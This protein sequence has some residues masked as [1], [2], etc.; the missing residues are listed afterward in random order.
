MLQTHFPGKIYGNKIFKHKHTFG[1]ERSFSAFLFVFLLKYSSITSFTSLK[2]C[3]HVWLLV[4]HSL[5]HCSACPAFHF[6]LVQI[7]LSDSFNLSQCNK[8]Q[9]LTFHRKKILFLFNISVPLCT[10]KTVL[11]PDTNTGLIFYF[12]HKTPLCRKSTHLSKAE[13]KT[14]TSNL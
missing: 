6:F 1:E 13:S 3:S 4:L 8:D 12:A 5:F 9:K 14:T 2:I 11:S 10:Q 7:H